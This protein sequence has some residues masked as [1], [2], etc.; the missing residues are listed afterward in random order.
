ML[1]QSLLL[2]LL[3]FV[4]I[5]MNCKMLQ[6]SVVLNQFRIIQSFWIVISVILAAVTNGLSSASE[7][8]ASSLT[9]SLSSAPSISPL[10]LA[11]TLQKRAGGG[12]LGGLDGKSG[13]L[14][15]W[16]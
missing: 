10:I 7:A 16:K 15:N 9:S 13:N 8:A 4:V 11:S 3:V 6:I 5:L 2:F 14:G 1:K 12:G